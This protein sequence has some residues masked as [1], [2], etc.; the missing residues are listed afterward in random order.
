MLSRRFLVLLAASLA[1]NSEAVDRN[2]FR[3]CEQ[4]HFCN[5][6]RN[7]Q[8]QNMPHKFHV[9]RD[10][11]HTDGDANLV[12][13]LVQDAAS[14]EDIPLSGSLAFVLHADKA[15]VPVVRVRL[16]EKFEDPNDPK[17]RWISDDIL[18][19]TA[20]E[21]RP[22]LQVKAQDAGLKTPI[23]EENVVLFAPEM[24]GATKIVAALKL[25]SF[26]VDLY[27][28]G[29]KL[30]SS[31]NENLFHYEIR[32]DRVD[33][34]T[35]AEGAVDQGAVDAHEGKKI[36]DYGEDG[37]AIY[38]DGSV[39]KKEEQT[40][41]LTT[42]I[43][44]DGNVE[45]WEE[46]FD[47]HTDKKK[48]GPSSLG[49]DVTF[50][51]S[52]VAPRS[53]Y[54][55]PE[56]ATD[57][58]LKDTIEIDEENEDKREIITDP[59]RLYN[60][61]VFE[62][63]L[64]NPMALYGAIPVLVAPN[65]ENTVGLF[66]NNP[67]ETFVDI[68]SN[69]ATNSKVSHWM[70]ESG[71]LDLF[72]LS[73]PN[74]ADLFAQ[75]TLLTGRAQLPPL[76]ALG[77][78]QCR[79]NYKNEV[80]VARV[81]AGF[82]EHLI[83]YDV[84]WLDIE[85]TDGK[86]YFTWDHHAFP[87]PITMQE[88]I[89]RTGR[90]MVTIIDPHIKVSQSNDAMPYYIH[91]E[92]QELGLFIKDEEGKDF[93][94]WCWPGESSYVDF[95]SS[96]ARAWW[97]DQFRYE[98]YQG[99]TKHLYTWND[100]NE[101]SVFNGPEVSMRKGCRSINDVEHREWHN[102]YGTL[103]QRATMEGQLVRQQ[104]PHESLL[105]FDDTLQL[106]S[107][108]QR[109]FVLSR[110]FS[111][112]SQRYGAI[113][114]GDNKAEWG[115]LRYATKMLL[116]MS[117]VGLTFVGADVG[118]FFGNPSS[119]LFIRWN[120]A[121]VYHPFFR[122]HAHHDSPRREPWVFGDPTTSIVR[123]AIRERYALLPYLYTL[124]HTCH[125]HGMPIM[126]PLWIHFTQEPQNF[127]EEDEFLLGDALLVKPIVEENVRTTHVF[128]PSDT[129]QGTTVWYHVTH[130]YKRFI[131]GA[132]YENIPAPLDAIPV[133]HRG[134]TIIPRKQR[135]RRSSELMRNDPLTLVVALNHKFEAFG[136]LY[137]DDE[138]S[139][140]AE[141]EGY[142][143]KVE[144]HQTKEGLRSIAVAAT[145]QGKRYTSLMWVERIEIYGFLSE[146]NLPT[147]ILVGG[148]R[149][150]HFHYDANCDRL[151]VRKPQVLVTD[152]WDLRFVYNQALE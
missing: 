82:D 14:P 62:Y 53:L 57:F 135:V 68:W 88:A 12:R 66:W 133:F 32:K 81:D 54:G 49:F 41:T 145:I 64:D 89:A 30:I 151:V 31:N 117:V 142:G 144:L 128:L 20:D 51:G 34:A 136:Q 60:L 137:V 15:V 109:P 71:V 29:E 9:A 45:G 121:A 46:S 105:P 79:W 42:S 21:T 124:F 37:L 27:L 73:G 134:G 108:M 126:R 18:V 100:M 22:L 35:Q 40:D 7:V 74:S 19:P 130:G 86:R 59:Y 85:H 139:L 101:P 8:R 56:H 123:T 87:S 97:R 43:E 72:L 127:S 102:L 76:F 147:Q 69:E 95:T 26:G 106:T 113:W 23:N 70:S 84:L 114:T 132:T 33:A 78:H 107:E 125:T 140:A 96:K 38:D 122:G 115:H 152:N 150:L 77:Y 116:S 75:Y 28:N 92:A 80:D 52:I 131:G 4:T 112:G 47:G 39:Q 118:G 110:A 44:T 83:P 36:V 143:T 129:T 90:K 104:P 111:A 63:E 58:V 149:A 146:A 61:D 1:V 3:T 119:E 13:F 50:H 99:S 10:S 6:Y 48:F 93:K 67:S 98:K 141:L 5:K 138:H 17:T 65:K 11:V 25:D 91:T 55:I 103:F 24:Q 16:E 120:Q 94:G 148:E 2:K